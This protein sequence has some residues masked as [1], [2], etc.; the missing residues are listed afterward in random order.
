MIFLRDRSFTLNSSLDMVFD[1]LTLIALNA[2]FLSGFH[3]THTKIHFTESVSQIHNTF[4]SRELCSVK[5]RSRLIEEFDYEYIH[6]RT[7]IVSISNVNLEY[8]FTKT[9]TDSVMFAVRVTNTTITLESASRFKFDTLFM[10][11]SPATTMLSS[12]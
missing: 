4:R 9:A 7:E 11:V 2:C 1:V 10:R 3:R 6:V 12:T 5:K 8:I